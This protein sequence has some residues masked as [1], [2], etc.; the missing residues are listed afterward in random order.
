MTEPSHGLN[1]E[2]DIFAFCRPTLLQSKP[3]KTQ[4]SRKEQE[5]EANLEDPAESTQPPKRPRPE[6][7]LLIA[8][9]QPATSNPRRQ[10]RPPCKT[11]GLSAEARLMAKV[12]CFITRTSWLRSGWTRTSSAS[13]VKPVSFPAS[14]PFPWS[15]M[16]RK[17]RESRA[18]PP[19]CALFY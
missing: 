17:R 5:A 15:G 11:N 19:H 9:R 12:L 10:Q 7:N 14:T 16:P 4:Q 18:S 3:P 2:A 13:C 8:S 1:P 6:P